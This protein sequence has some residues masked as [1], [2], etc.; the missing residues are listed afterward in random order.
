[1]ID[2]KSADSQVSNPTDLS[3][4]AF[5][6]SHRE[7]WTRAVDGETLELQQLRQKRRRGKRHRYPFFST[8]TL[9]FLGVT[10]AVILFTIGLCYSVISTLS[11]SPLV[12]G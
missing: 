11:A 3:A 9:F 6:R 12:Q 7:I 1:M 10:V 2:S 4:D 8:D 5:S